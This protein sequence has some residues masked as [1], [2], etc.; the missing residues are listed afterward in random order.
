[1]R[2]VILLCSSLCLFIL[3]AL[4]IHPS[5]PALRPVHPGNMDSAIGYFKREAPEFAASCATLRS[6]IHTL[7]PGNTYSLKKARQQLLLCRL[8][9]KRMESFLEYFFRSSATIYNR[10]PKFEAETGSMEYQAPIGLQVIESLLYDKPT[11]SNCRELYQQADAIT[12]SAADLPALLYGLS[13]NDAR[14][15]ESLRLELIRII[16]LSIT[17]Y[18]A[19]LLKSGLAESYEA[20]RSFQYQLQ[21]SLL[22]GD[23][24]SD[25]VSSAL[26]TALTLLAPAAA[27]AGL[28]PSPAAATGTTTTPNLA[29][30]RQSFDQFD[31]MHFLVSAM[32]PLQHQLGLLIRERQLDLNTNNILNYDA[33]D[34]FSPDALTADRFPG[35]CKDVSPEMLLIGRQLFIETALSGNGSKNCASCHSPEKMFTDQLPRSIAFDGH[36]HLDRN[37]PSLLYSGFQ[38]FQFWDGRVSTLEDQVKTVLHDSREMNGNDSSILDH[39]KA[40]PLYAPLFRNSYH[41]KNGQLLSGID[42]VA[43][44]LASYVRSL[45]PMNSAFDRYMQGNPQTLNAREIRGANLF[46]GRAQCATCH[47]IPLFNGLIPPDYQL[48]EF[49]ILG[50]TATDQLDKPTPGKDS[51]RYRVYPMDFFRGSFKTPTVRNTAKTFPYMHDGAF[52]SLEK[53]M[54]FYNRGG[55]A[56]LGLKVPEQTLSPLPLHLSNQDMQDII[57]FL[58]A[59]TDSL[60]DKS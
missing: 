17:G 28:L 9:Y 30:T 45:H 27:S 26:H 22:P 3:P 54:E 32:L 33:H 15:L 55:G 42:L 31:R 19:P 25:S 2:L 40:I 21:P 10:P 18:D 5:A 14:L 12:E 59:L 49:E 11:P 23:P 24:R 20:L 29:A 48:T 34:L 16:T 52:H 58:H 6:T 56:G 53:V 36:S 47:F 51:G 46:M 60:T 57:L 8:H 43:Y 35:G 50:A 39:L 44:A 4:V 37:A 41:D 1:M 7:T 13:A 38:Y